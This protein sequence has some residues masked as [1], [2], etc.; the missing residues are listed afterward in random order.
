VLTDQTRVIFI[1][2][3]FGVPHPETPRW[4][5]EARRRGIPLVEDCA[6]TIDSRAPAGWRVGEL[7]D[8]VIVSLPKILPVAAGGVLIGPPVSHPPAAVGGHVGEV[9]AGWWPQWPAHAERRRQVYRELTDRLA[10]P[11]RRPL[12]AVTELIT[13]WFFPVAVKSVAATLAWGRELAVDCAH[14]HGTDLVVFPCHQFLE[15]A[16]LGRIIEVIE[17]ADDGAPPEHL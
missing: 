9:A 6:H 5:D 2:H 17:R 4:R 7:A 10:R 1:I 8:W 14:W 3:E 12:F 13:P 16:Q 11:G 15:A